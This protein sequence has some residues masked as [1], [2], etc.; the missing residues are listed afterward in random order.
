[1]TDLIYDYISMGVD[2]LIT[3]AIVS[4]IVVLLRSTIILNQYSANQQASAERVNYYKEFN[5]YDC[6][7][8]LVTADMISAMLYYRYD[9]EVV[10]TFKESGGGVTIYTN[11]PRPETSID[12]TIYRINKSGTID[13][14]SATD[15]KKAVSPN[16]MYKAFLYEESSTPRGSFGSYTSKSPGSPAS[17]PNDLFGFPS[18]EG[19]SGG[20]ITGLYFEA[21]TQ[22][23]M[24]EV[25]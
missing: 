8:T 5:K 22:F 6:T 12:G 13:T 25:V 7:D 14:V 1:M 4:A 20:L 2:M 19:Y 15:F 23:N 11:K 21:T 18:I 10:V 17:A 9:L 24:S 16:W 3:A